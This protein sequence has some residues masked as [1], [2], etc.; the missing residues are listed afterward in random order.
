MREQMRLLHLSQ[1][2]AGNGGFHTLGAE[3]YGRAGGLLK[4]QLA[5]LEKFA[6]QLAQT[7]A[8]ALSP[9]FPQRAALYA[10]AGRATYERQRGVAHR[11]AGFKWERNVLSDS[12][13][14][15]DGCIRESARGWVKI[16][17]LVPIGLRDCIVRDRCSLEYSKDEPE[18]GTEAARRAFQ[19][20]LNALPEDGKIAV[21][22][23]APEIVKLWTDEIEGNQTVILLG[24]RRKHYLVD[25]HQDMVSAE[26]LI[27]ETVL[28][29]DFIQ[30]DKERAAQHPGILIYSF[31]KRIEANNFLHVALRVQTAA[32]TYKHSIRSAYRRSKQEVERVSRKPGVTTVWPKGEQAGEEE[33]E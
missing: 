19:K 6:Q 33:E 25:R 22:E 21:G 27:Q 8:L 20:Q 17:T 30:F 5:Y 1:L 3:E 18:I 23:L 29:P 4:K 26:R 24:E 2:A 14:A 7:P 9:A 12:I 11:K 28:N 16:G 13:D 32:G 31:Y 15:C 10:E